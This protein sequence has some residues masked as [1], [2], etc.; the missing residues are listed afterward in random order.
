MVTSGY[1]CFTPACKVRLHKHC[2]NNHRRMRSDCP[3]CK[4]EWGVDDSKLLKVGEQAFKDGQ[5]KGRRVRSVGADEDGDEDDEEY[6]E[7]SQSQS[8]EPSE[9]S[10]TQTKVKKEKTAKGKGKGKKKVVE[11]DEDEEM[12]DDDETPP[13]RTQGKRKARQ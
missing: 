12:E 13:P 6:D 11:S 2:Y 7:Q 8:Q 10:Q 1:S 3:T 4:V 5:E 9:P